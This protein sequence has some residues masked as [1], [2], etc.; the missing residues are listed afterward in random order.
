MTTGAVILAFN[1]GATDYVALARQSASRIRRHLGWPTCL[2]TDRPSDG[3]DHICVI[4]NPG[5][6]GTREFHDQ[7]AP[8][9]NRGRN[10]VYALTPWEHTVL[11]DADYV[12]ASD[13]LSVLSQCE[14]DI[15]VMG[16]S[17]DITGTHPEKEF[18][19]FGRQG[20]PMSWAT[21]ISFRKS[22]LS[23]QVF[24][25]MMMVEKNWHH[26]RDIYG[27]GRRL[28]RNDYALSIALLITHGHDMSAIPHMPWS[29]AAV[30]PE[31]QVTALAPDRFRV[32]FTDT[33]GKPSYVLINDQDF[34]AMGKQQLEDCYA[35]TG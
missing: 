28:F 11:L 27:F 9:F 19:S 15:S 10:Q 35:H 22:T 6:G 23:Q 32:S 14:H 1:N 29:M 24:D 17:Y 30:Y 21:C 7:S 18:N 2:I 13:Q 5:A 34:H 31:H 12:V 3:F 16:H 4:D 26:Y 8:W 33:N 20:Y 25:V